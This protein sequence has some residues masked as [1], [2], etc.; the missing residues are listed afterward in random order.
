M[1]LAELFNYNNRAY[2]SSGKSIQ[3]PGDS[4]A[5]IS[6]HHRDGGSYTSYTFDFVMRMV[7]CTFGN[8]VNFIP[9]SQMDPEVVHSARDELIKR[10]GKPP[11]LP[12]SI[13]AP[14]E[15][16]AMPGKNRPTAG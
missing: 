9:F 2:G 13:Q 16:V 11:E 15:K 7:K 4:E 8:T 6:F 12:S 14:I 10:G 3:R 5:L 1:N